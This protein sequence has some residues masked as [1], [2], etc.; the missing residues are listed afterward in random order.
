MFG[1]SD[2][3]ETIVGAPFRGFGYLGHS[4]MLLCADGN[5][6]IWSSKG[7]AC[8]KDSGDTKILVD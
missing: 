7:K 5:L 6:G 3:T 8:K 4:V 2:N 1:L